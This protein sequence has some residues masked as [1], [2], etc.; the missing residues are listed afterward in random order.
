M[1]NQSSFSLTHIQQNK[2]TTIFVNQL[3]WGISAYYKF[4]C[5]LMIEKLK[6]EIEIKIG[7]KI[8]YQKDCIY[9]SANILEQS[10]AYISPATLRRVFGFLATNS[11]P[12]RV[13]LDILSRFVAYKDWDDFI[14]K[15]GRA[16][17]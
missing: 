8:S 5:K 12:S 10:K 1:S 4:L 9:L 14:Q 7:R 17:V 3:F 15:I 13:T 6:N 2:Q 16:H 11:N